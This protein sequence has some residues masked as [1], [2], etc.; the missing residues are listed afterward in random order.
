MKTNT[1]VLLAIGAIILIVGYLIYR[2]VESAAS[3][4]GSAVGTAVQTAAA[5][6]A[7]VVPQ[8]ISATGDNIE[9]FL[10][11]PVSTIGDT[12]AGIYSAFSQSDGQ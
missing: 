8:G 4:A 3:S 2:S 9:D 12:L 1:I 6:A 10:A 11:S 7:S 5:S